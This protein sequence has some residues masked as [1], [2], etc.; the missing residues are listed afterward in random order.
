[1][2]GVEGSEP[3]GRASRRQTLIHTILVESGEE[4]KGAR[5]H[6]E[7]KPHLTTSMVPPAHPPSADTPQASASISTRATSKPAALTCAVADRI[8]SSRD[9]ASR[10]NAMYVTPFRVTT[11]PSSQPASY[12]TS[13]S[14]P[15]RLGFARMSMNS[16]MVMRLARGSHNWSLVAYRVST[17]LSTIKALVCLWKE[18]ESIELIKQTP[19]Q[20][21]QLLGFNGRAVVVI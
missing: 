18:R 21:E 14:L 15:D 7:T 12:N 16:Y 6:P 19:F 9:S 11:L 3:P 8:A 1:M 4:S 5:W 17:S 13:Q 10:S 20:I 2:A